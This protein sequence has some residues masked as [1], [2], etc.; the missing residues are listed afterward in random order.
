MIF[1]VLRFKTASDKKLYFS[2]ENKDSIFSEKI[3]EA[4]IFNHRREAEIFYK[5]NLKSIIESKET[6]KE[7]SIVKMKAGE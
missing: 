5:E 3:H 2:D 4:K 6:Y 7:I 1:Y